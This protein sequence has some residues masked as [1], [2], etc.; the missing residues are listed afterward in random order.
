MPGISRKGD[1]L[2]TGHGCDAVTTLAIPT[3]ATVYAN[4]KAIARKTD[5]TVSHQIGVPPL[6]SGHVAAVTGGI[7]TVFV[8]GLKCSR[9]GDS[10]DSGELIEGSETVFAGG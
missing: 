10:T 3:Q 4:G 7:E 1:A 8:V 5:L 2:T 6:C 9:I